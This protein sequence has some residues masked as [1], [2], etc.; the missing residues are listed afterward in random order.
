MLSRRRF[1]AT[2]AAT[3]IAAPALVRAQSKW[4]AQP[5]SLGIA[6]GDPSPDGFVIWTRIAPQPLEPHGGM[7]MTVL[8]VAW[9]VA[10]EAFRSVVARGSAVARPELAHSV[11]VEVAGL[12]PDR[13]YFYRFEV[14]GERS[15]VGRARTL[16]LATATPV[17][18]RLG[19]AGCQ[20]YQ[21][22]YFT[23]FRHLAAEDL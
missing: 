3:L 20:D 11:H 1:V 12:K 16:P 10:D 2:S 6:S 21:G 13:P 14:G 23:A 17:S 5:F 15:G 19:V 7:P 18:L 22:G 9:E 8:P 4:R